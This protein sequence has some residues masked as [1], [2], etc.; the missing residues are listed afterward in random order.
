MAVTEELR[1][2]A[3]PFPSPSPTELADRYA[4]SQLVKIYALGVDMRDY[5]VTRSVFTDDAFAEGTSFAGPIDDYLPQA[6]NGAATYM[7]TQHNIINQHVQI[8]GPDE[9]LVWS[10]AIA[11]HHVAPEDTRPDLILGVQYRDSCRRFPKGW[12]IV[13]RKVVMMWSERRDPALRRAT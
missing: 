2:W 5:E 8:T 9:A 7:A 1:A 13:R 10:Y 4:A 6:H 3:G 11:V 12:M